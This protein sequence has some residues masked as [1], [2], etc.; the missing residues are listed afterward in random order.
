MKIDIYQS[1]K[2][3]TKYLCV[4]TDTAVNGKLHL[5]AQVDPD[6]LEVKPAVTTGKEVLPGE[7]YIGASGD[8][9]LAQIDRYGCALIGATVTVRVSS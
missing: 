3:S 2:N 8:E 9:I 6:F 4:P 7:H 1:K 5:P